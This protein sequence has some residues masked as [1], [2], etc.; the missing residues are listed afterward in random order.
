MQIH[1]ILPGQKPERQFNIPVRSTSQHKSAQ[2]TPQ[3]PTPQPPVLQEPALH[4]TSSQSPAHPVRSEPGPSPAASA[5]IVN[6]SINLDGAA[7][8]ESNRSFAKNT[9]PSDPSNPPLVPLGKPKSQPE[10]I[11]ESTEAKA[12]RELPPSK[13]LNSN[14]EPEPSRHDKLRRTDSET[15]EDDEFV[16]AQS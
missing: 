16:D 3:Q 8:L 4:E 6:N 2:Q 11:S 14:P 10:V 13:L 15:Q 7:P 1:A 12:A 5:P 9:F